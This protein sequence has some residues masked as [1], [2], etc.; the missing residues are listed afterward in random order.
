MKKSIL[1][2]DCS[3]TFCKKTDG[4]DKLESRGNKFDETIF[5]YF[6]RFSLLSKINKEYNGEKLVQENDFSLSN[7]ANG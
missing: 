5:Y 4:I 1:L 3:V 7:K 6:F 2:I